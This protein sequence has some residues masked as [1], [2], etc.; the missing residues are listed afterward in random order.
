VGFLGVAGED[1]NKGIAELLKLELCL[2]IEQR[3]SSEVDGG[4]RVLSINLDGICCSG[5]FAAVADS[6]IAK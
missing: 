3:E 5:S 2:W 4:S 1:R 6:N